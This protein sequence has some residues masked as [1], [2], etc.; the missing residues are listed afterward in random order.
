[1]QGEGKKGI[2]MFISGHFTGET[3]WSFIPLVPSSIPLRSPHGWLTLPCIQIA[4]LHVLSR[5]CYTWTSFAEAWRVQGKRKAMW[6][7]GEGVWTCSHVKLITALVV[8]PRWSSWDDVIWSKSSERL[9]EAKIWGELDSWMI[10]TL[11]MVSV[12]EHVK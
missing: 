7:G 11:A 6:A 4:H 5:S 2:Y 10:I 3:G 8:L 9:V 12:L 1:M